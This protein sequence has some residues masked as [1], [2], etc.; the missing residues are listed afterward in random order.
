[1]AKQEAPGGIRL[2]DAEERFSVILTGVEFFYRRLPPDKREEIRDRNTL[3][4][5]VNN[6]AAGE[7]TIRYC[8]LGW[9]PGPEGA[10]IRDR[11]GEEVLFDTKYI[12]ALPDPTRLG[13][14]AQIFG[15][16]GG[17]A[18]G[19]GTVLSPL[20]IFASTSVQ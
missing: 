6:E 8:V 19:E 11:N 7:E 2:V 12:D 10:T 4:G 16:V 1:M 14:V 15:T 18:I 13:L 9:G 17:E 3:R 5:V 20:A